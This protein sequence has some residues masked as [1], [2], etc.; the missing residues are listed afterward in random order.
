MDE[1]AFLD[2]CAENKG[3]LRRGFLKLSCIYF[4]VKF[5]YVSI[6]ALSV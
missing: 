4:N 3:D 5:S 1:E 6:R 2:L